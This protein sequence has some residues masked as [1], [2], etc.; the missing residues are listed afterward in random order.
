MRTKSKIL[1]IGSGES[2]LRGSIGLD[3]LPLKGVDVVHDLEKFPYPFA[4]NS[5]EKVVA[6]NC[7]EHISDSLNLVKEVHR[8]LKPNGVFHFEVPHFSSCDMYTDLTHK[9]FFS[10]RSMDYFVNNDNYLNNFKYLP[11]V[12]YKIID[13]KI[14]FWG[15]K[16]FLDKPQEYLFNKIPLFYERK[17]AWIFPAHQLVFN[18][19]AIK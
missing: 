8:I 9:T 1:D 5:F 4:D 18:L 12:N 13:R 10:F 15:S 17:L 3:I 6:F 14:T 7:L 11:E 16:R 19:K 2:K